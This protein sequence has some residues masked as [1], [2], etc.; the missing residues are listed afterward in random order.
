[1]KTYRAQKHI[2]AAERA[3][4]QGRCL[5]AGQEIDKAYRALG[6]RKS[7]RLSQLDAKFERRCVRKHPR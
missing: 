3:Y 2:Q 6:Q 5:V 7:V 4:A 1:M